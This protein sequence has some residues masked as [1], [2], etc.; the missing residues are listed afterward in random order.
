MPNLTN[1]QIT[2][3][4]WSTHSQR[5]ERFIRIQPKL[6]DHCGGVAGKMIIAVVE[7]PDKN[8]VSGNDR[9]SVPMD[10]Q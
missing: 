4:L 6:G 9:I 1:G 3:C 8:G 2:K 7:T 10:S 5:G